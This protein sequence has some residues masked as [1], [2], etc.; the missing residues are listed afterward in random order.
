MISRL[1]IVAGS[2][3]SFN[4]TRLEKYFTGSADKI[5]GEPKVVREMFERCHGIVREV[6][7][8]ALLNHP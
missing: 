5:F 2:F 1:D 8:L 4:G 6:R 7:I 3:L